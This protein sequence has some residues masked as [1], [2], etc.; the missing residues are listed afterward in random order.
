MTYLD[1]NFKNREIG[2]LDGWFCHKECA[3]D[4]NL[5]IKRRADWKP[6]DQERNT[7]TDKNSCASCGRYFKPECL[8][9]SGLYQHFI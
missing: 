7:P 6:I 5:K 1:A 4:L 8:E 3:S 2:T 9:T